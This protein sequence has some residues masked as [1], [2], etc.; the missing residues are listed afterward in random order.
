MSNVVIQAQV[1]ANIRNHR[2]TD[3]LQIPSN[4]I[5]IMHESIPFLPVPVALLCLFFNIILPGS[6]KFFG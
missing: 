5:T 2:L 6:G 1:A 4:D 3:K